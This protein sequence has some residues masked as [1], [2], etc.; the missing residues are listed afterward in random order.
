MSEHLSTQCCIVGCGP[1]G[2]MLG[3][4]LARQGI[5]VVV[6]EKHDD[7]LRDFR[8]DDL[9]AATM[10]ILDEAGLVDK[11]LALAV[12]RV[13]RVEAHTPAGTMLLAD[14]GTVRTRFP[15]IAVVP[16][17]DLLTMLATEGARSPGYH[18]RMGTPA[19]E[20][21]RTD[22]VVRGVRCATAHGDLTVSATLT[23]AAD[24]RTST[25]RADSGLALREAAPPID[26]L[27]FR[28]PRPAHEA[29]DDVMHIHLADGWAMARLDRGGYWQTACVIPKGAAEDIRAAGVDRLREAVATVMPDLA[30]HIQALEDWRQVH[31]LSVRTNRLRRWY[32]P[33]LLFIGDAA[34]AMSPIGG[35]GVNFAM[36]DAV[37]AANRLTGPLRAGRV[38]VRQ[39]AA[40]QRQRYWQVR[41]MQSFQAQ[42][43]KGYL[44]AADGNPRG[45][46]ALARRLGPKLMNLPGFC[47]VRS[48][49]T[50]LGL[51][52][53]HL[54]AGR[55][56]APVEPAAT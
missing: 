43:T 35:T 16:Q 24:G 42:L 22:G 19:T 52:R 13:Q 21:L 1:A 10:E 7:F 50:A 40:V 56:G 45:T 8:G 6:L 44:V 34:H 32:Q 47:V 29:P 46:R 36:Q 20:L 54:D 4:L 41:L 39:L 28:L 11:L 48:R 37:V 53:V 49:I 33:G 25:L 51:R 30:R 18:L 55:A 5:D 31:L 14:L 26:M 12:K 27:L 2:A 15:F 17:W 38:E 23:V 9:A 3:L